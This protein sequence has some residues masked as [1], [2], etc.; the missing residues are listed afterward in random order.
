M[1]LI[2]NIR[3]CRLNKFHLQLILNLILIFFILLP[4]YSSVDNIIRSS[5]TGTICDQM[6]KKI[7][8]NPSRNSFVC[9]L[10]SAPSQDRWKK[11]QA[12]RVE[13]LKRYCSKVPYPTNGWHRA[14]RY[15]ESDIAFI[16]YTGAP[17]Y[18]NRAKAV[19][20]TWV[21]RVTY[22][23]FLG[24]IAYESLPVTVVENTGEDYQS[25]TK[26]IFHGLQ[27]I[28][29]NQKHLPVPERHKWYFLCGCDTYVNVPHLLK[30]L[31]FYDYKEPYF[32]GGSVGDNLC[33]HKNGSSYKTVFVGGNSAHVYSAKL[34]DALHP[35]LSTY[36]ENIWPQPNH[37]SA[38][39]SDVA[40]SCLIFSLGYNMTVLPGFWKNTPDKII[41]EM[42]LQKLLAVREPSSWHYIEPERMIDLDEFYIYQRVDRL[43]NDL[44]WEELTDFY[45]D[46]IATHYKIVRKNYRQRC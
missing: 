16:I 44:N 35:L 41:K 8:A 38:G 4:S 19:R 28:Y 39:M 45:Y 9:D 36:V 17:F 27:Q 30:R 11:K 33:F 32:I 13:H 1:S 22:Y 21:S 12:H 37:T 42:G 5:D 6:N 15:Q 20:E 31:E 2:T 24:S 14:Q 34:V 10:S 46:F 25:N 43:L 7:R 29:E 40:L 3:P 23:Y 26:K 18:T